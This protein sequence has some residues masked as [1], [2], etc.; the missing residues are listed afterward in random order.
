MLKPPLFRLLMP[1]KYSAPASLR[2]LPYLYQAFYR[3]RVRLE[4]HPETSSSR[5]PFSSATT[6][7]SSHRTMA[8]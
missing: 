4:H 7:Y 8:A 3:H 2:H 6:S 1:P 5:H